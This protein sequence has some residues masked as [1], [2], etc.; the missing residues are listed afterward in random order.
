MKL[1]ENL[2]LRLIAI[3]ALAVFGLVL[4]PLSLGA[5]LAW[6]AI[7]H[8]GNRALRL[9]L[10][11]LIALPS[12]A[13]GSVWVYAL[14]SDTPATPQA[15]AAVSDLPLNVAD[16][17]PEAGRSYRVT[18][19]VDGDTIHVDRDGKDETVRLIGIDTPESVHPEKPVQ[20]FALQASSRLKE[21]IE[22]Q[23]VE[24]ETDPSQ[25]ERDRYGRL[26]AYVYRADGLFINQVLLAEGFA[27]EY[28]Y[29][30]AYARQALFR[31]AAFDAERDK[32]GLWADDACAAESTRPAQDAPAI[33]PA[34]SSQPTQAPAPSK[35][36]VAKSGTHSCSGNTYNCGDF[37]THAQAQ[38]VYEQCGGVSNDVHRLDGDSDGIACETLP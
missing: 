11:A 10:V 27:H 12:L 25:G 1:P 14:A 36:A 31:T 4:W 35:P 30:G 8:V 6:L 23:S 28:T 16:T 24:L 15:P 18:R 2:L 33:A 5:L 34:A 13:F 17:S 22:G 20:C 9:A 29:D 32:R 19:V 38:G 21:L 26:L 3:V 7:R 37:S